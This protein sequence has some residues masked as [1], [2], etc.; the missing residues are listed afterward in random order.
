ME[1][2]D[3]RAVI[4]NIKDI[5]G[6]I[7]DVD[8]DR[9]RIKRLI[10][11]GALT[12]VSST[13]LVHRV[14]EITYS[15]GI[16]LLP[17]DLIRILR[18][19]DVNGN[20]VGWSRQHGNTRIQM[21]SR[22]GVIHLYYRGIE[23]RQIDSEDGEEQVISILPEAIEYLSLYVISTLLQEQ[24][25]LGNIQA[26]KMQWWENKCIDAR[27]RAKGGSLLSIDE[28]EGMIGRMHDGQ[29]IGRR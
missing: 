1:A 5:A 12:L 17:C 4:G 21:A 10:H 27:P 11:K 24:W 20:K 22:S 2:V 8:I 29:F 6:S 25:T 7:V 23:L 18:I 15:N 3:Y 13:T 26:D 19:T 28:I 9:G 14:Q 16:I